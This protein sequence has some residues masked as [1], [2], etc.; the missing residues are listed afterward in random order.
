[1]APASSMFAFASSMLARRSSAAADE[2]LQPVISIMI[3]SPASAAMRSVSARRPGCSSGTLS[4]SIS[5]IRP[6]ISNPSK[7]YSR[8]LATI[9]AYGQSGHPS[10]ENPSLIMQF[11]R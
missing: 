9:V 11:L 4:R 1:M 10:V 8:A 7:P 3:S 2:N 5:P 6:R